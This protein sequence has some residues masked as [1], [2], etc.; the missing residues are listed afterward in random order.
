MSGLALTVGAL[1]INATGLFLVPLALRRL[2]TGFAFVGLTGEWGLRLCL[3][4][5]ELQGCR[6]KVTS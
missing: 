4:T 3:T 6:S 2:R 5:H 1:V